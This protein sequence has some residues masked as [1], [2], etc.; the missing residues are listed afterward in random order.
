MTKYY[1]YPHTPY[2]S[3][4]PTIESIDETDKT[5]NLFLTIMNYTIKNGISHLK[6][7]ER[8]QLSTEITYMQD[9]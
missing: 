2:L 3:F 9:L 4:S 8:T 7:M 6:W 5:S 1:K